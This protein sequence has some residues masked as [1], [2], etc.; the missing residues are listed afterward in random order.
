MTYIKAPVGRGAM[1]I[2]RPVNYGPVLSASAEISGDAAK[3]LDR[4]TKLFGLA[5][6]TSGE[7]VVGPLSS[8]GVG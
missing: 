4:A 8:L 6:E 2:R 3:R 1:L 5:A 7:G